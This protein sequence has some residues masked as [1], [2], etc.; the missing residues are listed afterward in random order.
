MP[1]QSSASVLATLTEATRQQLI[2]ILVSSALSK[3]I[4]RIGQPKA[5]RNVR[6]GRRQRLRRVGAADDE[7]L[8]LVARST[9]RP[10][11][12]VST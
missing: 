9:A 6:I 12:S 3:R 2:A 4:G 5:S 8:G 1:S 7:A 11:I 10:K